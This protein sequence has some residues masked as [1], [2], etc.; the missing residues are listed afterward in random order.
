GVARRTAGPPPDAQR[1]MAYLVLE[2]ELPPDEAVALAPGVD[3]VAVRDIDAKLARE[4][5]LTRRIALSCS[6]PDWLAEALVASHG[7]RAEAMARALQER[8]PMTLRANTLATS[9]ADLATWLAEEGVPTR[10]TTHARAGLHAEDRGNLFGLRAYERG[11]FEM[12]DE[13]SQMICELVAPPERSV[14]V[15]YCAGAGGK[16]LALAALLGNR[17]RVVAVDVDARK[18]HELRRRARR[19][20]VG[21]VQAVTLERESGWPEALTR[22]EGTVARVLVDAP[23]SAVGTLRRHPEIRWRLSAEEVARYPE[24]QVQLCE[25]ALSLLAPGGHLIYATC[26]LLAPENQGVVERVLAAHP[27]VSLVPVAELAPGLWGAGPEAPVTAPVPE[28]ITDPT[29]RYLLLDPARR[30][31]Q[32]APAGQGTDGFF[33]AVLR[34]AV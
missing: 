23:C 15:D 31:A 4:P 18:L 10:P 22:L 29:G 20:G 5:R 3:W 7:D 13:G 28:P 9:R 34:R 8:A 11:A 2:A 21:N 25:R 16:T 14:V 19:A 32:A 30:P 27:N 12:Q 17:G 24:L 1:V 6:L 26:T 33:A